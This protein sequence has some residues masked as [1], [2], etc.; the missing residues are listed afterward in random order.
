MLDP[1]TRPLIDPP[2]HLFAKRL[3][4]LGISSNT[5]T[6]FGFAA[7]LLAIAAVTHECF[8]LAAGLFLINRLV[9]GLDGAVARHSQPS[10]FGGVLDIICDFIIYSGIVFAFGLVDHKN[11]Y[12]A[13]FLLFSFIG[14]T[15]TLR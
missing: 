8:T 11:L 3:F 15:S 5:L 4:K 14:A 7:G 6:L 9:D 13:S 1:Y 2:L 10:D 12:Y